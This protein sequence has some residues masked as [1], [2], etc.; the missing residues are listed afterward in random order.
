MSQRNQFYNEDIYNNKV[1]SLSKEVLEDYILELRAKNKSKGTIKQYSSDI[2]MFLCWAYENLRDKYILDMKKRDFRNFFLALSDSGKSSA[3]INRVQCSLR[4]VLEFCYQDDDIYEDYNR[5]V[6]SSIKGL[7]K[8]EV[9]DIVF[10]EDEKITFLINYYLEK[11]DYQKA[12]YISL[13]YDSAGRRNE[14][15]QV[16][17]H[18]FANSKLTNVVEGKRGKSFQ[19]FYLNRTQEIA[20]LYL[21][22]RGEDDLDTLWIKNQNGEKKKIESKTLYKWTISMRAVLQE[23]Y[24]EYIPLNAHSFRHSALENYENGTHHSLQYLGKDN[25]DIKHL[26]TLANHADTATTESYLKDK[27]DEELKEIFGI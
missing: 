8:Q 3:R 25:L 22:K 11:E 20:K 10:L 2:K 9:R 6:M 1:N 19:L 17:K 7:E 18:G 13:A 16:Q 5:N 27:D 23:K 26:K 12:L 24:G 4:N 21:D 15:Y 14:I